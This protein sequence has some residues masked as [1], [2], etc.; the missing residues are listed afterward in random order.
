MQRRGRT[1]SPVGLRPRDDTTHVRCA[2]CRPPSTT[3]CSPPTLARSEAGEWSGAWSVRSRR[4]P[5]TRPSTTSYPST[6][7]PWRRSLRS[8]AKGE[9]LGLQRRHVDLD[10]AIVRVEHALQEVTG[11]GPVLVDPKTAGSRR[12]VTVPGFLVEVLAEHLDQHVGTSPDSLLFTNGNGDPVLRSVWYPAWDEAR[13]TVGLDDVRLHDLR[14]LAGTPT[15]QAGATLKETMAWLGH[16]S[17]V[18]SLR[19]Q[20]VTANRTP[21]LQP[22]STT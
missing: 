12:T 19:Y 2:Q 10:L 6:C 4:S 15:A 21:R 3:S 13:K 17:V 22:V 1:S 5:S 9:I 14:H 7:R 8:P 20:H 16:S 18:A 11:K